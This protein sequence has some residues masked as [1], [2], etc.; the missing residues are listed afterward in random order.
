MQEY[1]KLLFRE[2]AFGVDDFDE[3]VV[4]YLID[5]AEDIKNIK[6]RRNPAAHGDV[7]GCEDAEFC[8][9]AIIKVYNILADFIDKISPRYIE[10]SLRDVQSIHKKIC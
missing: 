8:S 7:V 4:N 2:D 3:A 9:D 6:E 5:F 10:K 1:A